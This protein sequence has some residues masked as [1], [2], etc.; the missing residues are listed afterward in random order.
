MD[1]DVSSYADNLKLFDLAYQTCGRVDH[2]VAA[3]GI[4]DR[5]SITD[6]ALTMDTIRE[7]PTAQLKTMDVCLLGPIYFSRIA[8]VY[9]RQPSRDQAQSPSSPDKSLTLISSV[10]GL[11]ETPG[12]PIYSAAKHGVIGLMR[13][14]RPCVFLLHHDFTAD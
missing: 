1:V 4:G 14:L 7:A 9:L 13:S 8:S 2:A 3:A 12:L 10:A 6:P 5:G 11:T